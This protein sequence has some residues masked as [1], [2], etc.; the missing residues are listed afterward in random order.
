VLWGG[1]ARPVTEIYNLL[2]FPEPKKPVM[3]VIGI[4]A[5]TTMVETR[6]SGPEFQRRSNKTRNG[7]ISRTCKS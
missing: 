5:M 6:Q 4:M 2:V 7:K 1:I 3:M